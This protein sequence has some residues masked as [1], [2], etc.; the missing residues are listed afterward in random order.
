MC[1]VTHTTLKKRECCRLNTCSA[2]S[3]RQIWKSHTGSIDTGL[4]NYKDGGKTGVKG[5]CVGRVRCIFTLPPESIT[6]WFPRGR[7]PPKYLAYVEWFTP[8]PTSPDRNH[9]LYKISKL[10]VHGE[11]QVSIVP[12][13]LI[14]QSVH[15]FRNLA[16]ARDEWKSTNVLDLCQTFFANPFS[17]RFP[18]SNLF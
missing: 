13:Q 6:H 4:V 2:S 10:H 3:H 12:V 15:L 11:Q 1:L 7:V 18:Y 17:D 14:R 9:L 8:F 16:G 5:H